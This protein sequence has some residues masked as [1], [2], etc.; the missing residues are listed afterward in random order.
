MW[1]C[2]GECEGECVGELVVVLVCGR[3]FV[4]LMVFV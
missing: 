2:V 1:I 3:L 4:L